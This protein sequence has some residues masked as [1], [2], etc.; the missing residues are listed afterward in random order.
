MILNSIYKSYRNRTRGGPVCSCTRASVGVET[1]T[2]D[3]TATI[4][5][6]SF[7][8]IESVSSLY[9]AWLWDSW[10]EYVDAVHPCLADKPGYGGYRNGIRDLKRKV[11]FGRQLGNSPI[12]K[13]R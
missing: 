7:I 4:G 6:L 12:R 2:V 3:R 1:L 8:R 11:I 10:H 9:M 13:R 5:I